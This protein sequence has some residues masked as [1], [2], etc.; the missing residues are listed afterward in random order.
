MPTGMLV[1][2]QVTSITAYREQTDLATGDIDF[3]GGDI[4]NNEQDRQYE[5]FTQE[6]R[7][8]STG[9]NTVDWLV[10]GF[11]FQE[12]VTSTQDIFFGADTRD[13]ADA[14]IRGQTNNATNLV[15]GEAGLGIAPFNVPA[16]SFFAD[17]SGFFGDYT[18]DNRSYSLF[19][20]VD[21]DLSRKADPDR[22]CCVFERP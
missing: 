7:I 6:L 8:A 4:V 11:F 16:G 3:S 22:R 13:W 1:L 14:L 9:D 18:L 17:G 19:A 10:G 2:V 12:D 5:T 20:Q 21:I 15:A